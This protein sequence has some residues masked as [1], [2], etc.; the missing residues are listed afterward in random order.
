[1]IASG[2]PANSLAYRI[3]GVVFAVCVSLA[4]GPAF[5]QAQGFARMQRYS[6]LID[7]YVASRTF[8]RSVWP[9]AREM[10]GGDVAAFDQAARIYSQTIGPQFR[11]YLLS[12]ERLNRT[13]GENLAS[14]RDT[15]GVVS[16]GPDMP[17]KR[18]AMRGQ[19]D[20]LAKILTLPAQTANLAQLADSYG[21][22]LMQHRMQQ[23]QMF[24][25]RGEQVLRKIELEERN[26]EMDRRR[27]RID[28]DRRH[29]EE[30]NPP[31][32]IFIPGTN[33]PADSGDVMRRGHPGTPREPDMP[34]NEY[35]R[36]L[37]IPDPL[38]RRTVIEQQQSGYEALASGSEAALA[39]LP[40]LKSCIGETKR[41]E[42]QVRE[43]LA[44]A[45]AAEGNY[46]AIRQAL[47]NLEARWRELMGA[48]GRC[49]GPTVWG[50]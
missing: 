22:Q 10:G 34:P 29:D 5:A 12:L 16:R 7:S 18:T 37:R 40:A 28:G 20:A 39:A 41:P 46:E 35:P 3:G 49:S 32:D 13:F 1:M 27:A 6:S 9:D 4:P 42:G 50:D 45:L 26:S 15:L 2:L 47:N 17:Q 11:S 48:V 21:Q 14:A 19:L 30:L 44:R 36:V 31:H 33:Y 38:P 43:A 8:D 25:M 23:V 24:H